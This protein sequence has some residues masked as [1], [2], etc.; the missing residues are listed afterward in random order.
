MSTQNLKDLAKKV[1][2]FRQDV[3]ESKVRK[4]RAEVLMHQTP[5]GK[6]AQA[7]DSTLALGHDALIKTEMELKSAVLFVYETDGEKS[8]IDKV[9][10]KIFRSLKYDTAKILEW[11]RA[12]APGV[13]IVNKKP[14]EKMAV[15]IGAPVEVVEEPKCTL[16]TDMSVY[17]EEEK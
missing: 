17:L 11:C 8:P 14:F 4:E 2:E 16:A 1:A 13:L 5:E 6:D 12:N 7:A 10:V 15:D 9:V 3:A